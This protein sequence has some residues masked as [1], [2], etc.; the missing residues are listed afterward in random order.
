MA[1]VRNIARDYCKAQG[2]T[3]PFP[4]DPRATAVPSAGDLAALAE[5]RHMMARAYSSLRPRW[6]AVLWLTEVERRPVAD[7]AS[8]AGMSPAAVSQLAS[9]ARI[10]LAVAW[11]R[12]RG[13]QERITGPLPALRILAERKRVHR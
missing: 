11:Q 9:R 5:E 10:G 7:L 12:E 1:A 13:E 3:G 4:A 8:A 2:K 6:R